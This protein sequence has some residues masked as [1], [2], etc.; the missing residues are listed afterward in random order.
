MASDA[1]R[2]HARLMRIVHRWDHLGVER[3][4]NGALYIG[5]VPHQ[6][7]RAWLHRVF[8]PAAEA[9]I[10]RIEQGFPGRVP[11]EYRDFLATAN[12]LNLFTR[13]LCIYGIRAGIN[14]SLNAPAQ[15]FDLG[16]PNREE[17]V[18]GVPA[19][20]FFVGSYAAT[21]D[22]LAILGE[23]RTV[24][25]CSRTAP[26]PLQSWPSFAEMLHSEVERYAALCDEEGRMHPSTF[27][28]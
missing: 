3:M 23:T 15:P 2:L 28:I 13:R 21:G 20:A 16:R 26:D 19:D 17:R 24:I 9:A 25:R 12:G 5:R 27:G 14:R 6:G 22:K 18:P 4:P 11:R 8:G 1:E 7:S 10:A